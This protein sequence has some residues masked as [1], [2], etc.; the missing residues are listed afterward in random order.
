MMDGKI[1]TKLLVQQP[2]ERIAPKGKFRILGI[3]KF[4]PPGE[5]HWV[6]GDYD[7]LEEA[8]RYAR[9]RTRQAT[10]HTEDPNMAIVY[11]VYDDQGKYMGGD[12]YSYE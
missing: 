5:G 12:I 1:D 7:S 8:L 11:Y 4:E 2:I 3:D 9:A 10:S 6:V